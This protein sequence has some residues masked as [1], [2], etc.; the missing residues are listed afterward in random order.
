MYSKD[1][2]EVLDSGVIFDDT[3]DLNLKFPAKGYYKKGDAPVTT[4]SA[5]LAAVESKDIEEYLIQHVL[6]QFIAS[7]Y[8]YRY[9]SKKVRSSLMS[10][11]VVFLLQRT[12]KR[13]L[14]L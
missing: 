2:E 6:M 1:A 10:I 4:M 3:R 11:W 12:V 9:C 7:E 5:L 13:D 8:A 14:A